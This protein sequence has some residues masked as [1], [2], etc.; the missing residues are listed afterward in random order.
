MKGVVSYFH[1]TAVLP[2]QAKIQ[3]K[4]LDFLSFKILKLSHIYFVLKKWSGKNRNEYFF[5]F[6]GSNF[7]A[8]ME[9]DWQHYYSVSKRSGQKVFA[10]SSS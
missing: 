6:W 9:E 1:I 2:D 3:I 10:Y 4:L 5:I 8:S 7:E